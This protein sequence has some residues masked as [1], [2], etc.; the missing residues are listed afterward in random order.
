M[1]ENF[2]K[3]IAV[4]VGI[5]GGFIYGFSETVLD[6]YTL[7]QDDGHLVFL[8]DIIEWVFPVVFGITLAI[9]VRNYFSQK[10]L[11]RKLSAEMVG[12]KSKI[13]TNTFASYI[14]HEIRNPIHNLNAVLD[15]NLVH[16]PASEQVMV[17]RNTQKLTA[18]TNQLKHMHAL[19]DYMNVHEQIEFV[20]WFELFYRDSLGELLRKNK[21]HFI[22]EIQPT[23]LNMHPLLLEQCLLLLFDNALRASLKSSGEP[24]IALKV[25]SKTMEEN[26]VC[27]EISNSGPP[28]PEEVVQA[29]G[30]NRVSSEEGSGLG[31]V[32][33]RDT[34]K[35][36]GGELEL[37][38]KEGRPYAVIHI[39][40]GTASA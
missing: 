4:L 11:N 6:H 38:N 1:R 7:N 16:M 36:V 21:I 3:I 30:R 39:P 2:K 20:P 10:E 26:S 8:H 29:A 22:P 27:I 12:L 32:L 34:L 28:F 14:L 24:F 18:L 15:K 37:K 31:H 25:F 5:A 9:V 33:V 17:Q 19:S 35:H 13:L 23:R 40:K